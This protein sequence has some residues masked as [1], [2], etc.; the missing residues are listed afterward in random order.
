MARLA[1]YR[2]YRSSTLDDVIGQN[3]VVTTLKNAISSGKVSHAYLFCG[4][5]GV[6]KTSV[7]RIVAR[8]ANEL[9]PVVE[10]GSELDI[11]EIDAASN[12]GIDEMRS[13]R[14]KIAVAPS[15][16]K[17]K[18]YIIDE[19]HMLTRESFNALLKTLEEPPAHAIFV[20]ATTEAH[21]I[22]D[23]VVSRTQR[24][25]FRPITQTDL[26]DRLKYISKTEKIP[27]T[28]D[29][30]ELVARRSNGGFRDAISLLDQLS[31]T[32]S[33]ISQQTV[34]SLLGISSAEQL[35]KIIAKIAA[36][37]T[38]S[39]LEQ[40]HQVLESG[41]DPLILT[42]DLSEY[43]RSLL[44]QVISGKKSSDQ[45]ISA[46]LLVRL[47]D[48]LTTAQANFKITQHHSL[49][50]EIAIY[51]S[52]SP[53]APQPTQPTSSAPK[54]TS[55]NQNNSTVKSAPNLSR[56]A[57]PTGDDENLCLKGLSL[58]KS[59]NNSLYAL[60]RSAN[61]V[62]QGDKIM[63]KCRFSFHKERIEEAKN[64]QIIEAVMSKVT[65][66][67]ITL[68]CSTENSR[69]EDS[70]R[71]SDAELVSSALEILGGEVV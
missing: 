46:E 16:L 15:K 58:I 4:P 7:A 34:T 54:A 67:Q 36:A 33:K 28:D 63:L 25:D 66:R 13:L 64:R 32:G 42:R 50:L 47:I 1:L 3:H 61:P 29:A 11:I 49:P 62:L 70:S 41:I 30:I 45:N 69:K 26:V 19:V 17:Y 48:N 59:R 53:L 10:L 2:K 57:V 31:A 68:V 24:F 22:P 52:S 35:N 38:S 39:A 21:K 44:L 14:D 60:M 71:D 8:M 12:R 6:G 27:I 9:E 37:E 5:R 20:L 23:T 43:A 55:T 18:V 65:G 56:K 51:K 40:T